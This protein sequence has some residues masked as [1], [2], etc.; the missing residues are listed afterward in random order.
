MLANRE[1]KI[2]FKIN[3]DFSL[4]NVYSCIQLYIIIHT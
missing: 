2:N 1:S 3:K 4:S